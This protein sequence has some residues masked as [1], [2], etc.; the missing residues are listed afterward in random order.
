MLIA[1]PNM[2]GSFTCTLFFPYEG[3]Y[4]FN[5][6]QT[7]QQVYNFFKEVFTDTLDLIPNLVEEYFQNPISSLA[8]EDIGF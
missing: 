4:S 6:L 7:K 1:L 3:E 2:D 8:N 5:N